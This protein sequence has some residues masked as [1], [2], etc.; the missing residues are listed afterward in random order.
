MKVMAE[1]GLTTEGTEFH[2]ENKLNRKDRKEKAQRAQSGTRSPCVLC[3]FSLRPL[4]LSLFSPWN[5]V[6]S[7]SPW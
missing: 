4:R 2:G 7:V 6:P 3:V 1:K 5:S